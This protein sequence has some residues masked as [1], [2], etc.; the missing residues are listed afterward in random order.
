M[1]L[2]A[3]PAIVVEPASFAA[4]YQLRQQYR[5]RDGTTAVFPAEVLVQLYS[6]WATCATSWP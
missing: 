5:T 1:S 6:S 4:A 2:P 3:C